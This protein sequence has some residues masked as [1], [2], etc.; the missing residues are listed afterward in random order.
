[1]WIAVGLTSGHSGIH[2]PSNAGW[3]YDSKLGYTRFQGKYVNAHETKV[4]TGTDG[5]FKVMKGNHMVTGL[6]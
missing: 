3:K 4:K 6:C 5:A 1:M 2:G